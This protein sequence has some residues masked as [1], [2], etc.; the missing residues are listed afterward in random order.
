MIC[1]FSKGPKRDMTKTRKIEII[2]LGNKSNNK[3]ITTNAAKLHNCPPLYTM[4][5]IYYG[6]TWMEHKC[7]DKLLFLNNGIILTLEN[8]VV[9]SHRY[10]LL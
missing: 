4:L 2:W 6:W 8:F 5:N 9:G 3:N 1:L 10:L 7:N